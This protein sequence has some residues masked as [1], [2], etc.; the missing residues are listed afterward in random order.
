M[1]FGVNF[2][3][4]FFAKDRQKNLAAATYKSARSFAS[5]ACDCMRDLFANRAKSRFFLRFCP[6]NRAETGTNK[7]IFI[8]MI[9]PYGVKE[10]E[11]YLGTVQK[12]LTMDEL[13]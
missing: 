3:L 13:F 11:H 7:T 10:N 6:I 5:L 9:T 2:K 1:L 12:Q 4:I 8:T